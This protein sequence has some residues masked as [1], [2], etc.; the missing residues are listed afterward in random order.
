V[1]VFGDWINFH[2]TCSLQSMYLRE[3]RRALR[4]IKARIEST[5]L[6]CFHFSCAFVSFAFFFVPFVSST[7]RFPSVQLC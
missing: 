7:S 5:S 6:A 4:K 1:T 2:L 3:M